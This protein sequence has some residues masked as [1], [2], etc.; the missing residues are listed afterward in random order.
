VQ[1]PLDARPIVVAELT[2]IVGDVF[3]IGRGHW[4]VGEKYLAGRHARLGLAAEV[5]NDLEQLG[6]VCALVQRAR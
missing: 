4:A 3:E 5:E 2:D 6:R 1:R